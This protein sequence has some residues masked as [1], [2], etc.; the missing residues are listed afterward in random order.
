MQDSSFPERFRSA[1]QTYRSDEIQRACDEIARD[2]PGISLQK[3]EALIKYLN[4]PG[5]ITDMGRNQ[6]ERTAMSLP[7]LTP[8]STATI[9]F[10]LVVRDSNYVRVESDDASFY[11]VQYNQ[12]IALVFPIARC[13]IDIANTPEWV[14]WGARNTLD[15]LFAELLVNAD[16]LKKA[17]STAFRFSGYLIGNIR[18]YHYFYDQLYGLEWI[19]SKGLAGS[20]VRIYQSSGSNFFTVSA[21]YGFLHADVHED[22][23]NINRA[24]LSSRE[25]VLSPSLRFSS[26]QNEDVLRA[27]DLRLTEHASRHIQEGQRDSSPTGPMI[28]VGVC[29][30]KRSWA[31]A[32]IGLSQILCRIYEAH[33]GFV[34]VLDGW[35]STMSS[36]TESTLNIRKD[37]ALARKLIRMLP[38]KL[39]VINLIGSQAVEKIYWAQ[40]AD[41]FITHYAT[42]TMYVSRISKI[43]G[44]TF[45]STS[46]G[47]SLNN[48]VHHRVYKVPQ[49]FVV[50]L[51][52]SG[53]A[54]YSIPWQK[55]YAQVMLLWK[56]QLSGRYAPPKSAASS[57]LNWRIRGYQFQHLIERIFRFLRRS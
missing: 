17:D 52:S 4:S 5:F 51:P 21:A 18:P 34:L 24:L 15:L 7:G 1:F 3:L 35:T 37:Q 11:I 38:P 36:T 6:N 32:H 43:P 56:E 14:F 13:I 25:Y 12:Q 44:V 41:F 49:D 45:G 30:E 22:Y 8:E 57:N 42:D 50:D 33:P 19:A 20:S 27:L 54:S 55:V 29:S 16:L 26:V 28:W 31:E 9:A 2:A 47:P 48:H 46:T 39:R 40:K 23:S 53:A 10:T